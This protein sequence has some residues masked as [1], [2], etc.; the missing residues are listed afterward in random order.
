[1]PSADADRDRGARDPQAARLRWIV[2][3]LGVAAFWFSFFHRVAPAALAGEL[4]RAFDVSGAALGALAATYFY[5][6]AIM[7]LPTGVL[8]DTLGPRWTLAAGSLLAGIGSLVFA[9]A[10]NLATA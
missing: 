1:M 6:Y 2:F 10:S 4:T 8:A 7:Q 5:V 9:A 3:G